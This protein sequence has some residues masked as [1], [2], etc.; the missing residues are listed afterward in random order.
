MREISD[1][2][3]VMHEVLIAK[4]NKALRPARAVVLADRFAR[5]VVQN[6]CVRGAN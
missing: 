6:F 3:C 5:G 1:S 4:G 2:A